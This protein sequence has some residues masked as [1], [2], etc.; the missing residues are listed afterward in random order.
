MKDQSIRQYVRLYRKALEKQGFP[1]TEAKAGHYEERLS[2]ML[3]SPRFQEHNV[4]PSMNVELIYAVIAMCLEL[5]GFGLTD[6]EI[7]TFTE[8]VFARRRKFFDTLIRMIDLLPNS[9]QIAKK[10]NI[11]DH[12][13][14]VQD[15]SIIYDDFTVSENVVEYRISKCMYAEMF[16]TYGIRGLCKIFCNTDTRSYAGLRR[17][18]RFVRHSDLSDGPCCWDEVHRKGSR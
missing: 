6:K 1:D 9:F 4:Y 8:V 5:R 17:H 14:R 16:D 3:S 18:V 7:M 15:H 11:S 13:K 2:S 10:W 12:A